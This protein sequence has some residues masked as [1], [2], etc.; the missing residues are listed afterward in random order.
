MDD[1]KDG[2]IDRRARRMERQANPPELTASM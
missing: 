1:E 2:V